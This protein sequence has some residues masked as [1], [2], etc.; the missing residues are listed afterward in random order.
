V[1]GFRIVT[2]FSLVPAIEVEYSSHLYHK[3]T[4]Q[5]GG[6]ETGIGSGQEGKKKGK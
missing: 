1:T 6:G 5:A 3:N 4:P 2:T